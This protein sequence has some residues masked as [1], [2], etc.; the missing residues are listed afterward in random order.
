MVEGDYDNDVQLKELW[1]LS[2]L[3]LSQLCA[4]RTNFL[5]EPLFRMADT[6]KYQ[7]AD[8]WLVGDCEKSRC[9]IR[10]NA[11][12]MVQPSQF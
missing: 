11:H 9:P 5:S 10:S 7:D 2:A 6:G 8:W 12:Q 3:H 4:Y 1:Y